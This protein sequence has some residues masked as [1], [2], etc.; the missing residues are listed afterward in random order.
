MSDALRRSIRSFM[1][2]FLGTIISSGVVSAAGTNGVVDWSTLKK[3]VISLV[4]SF[5]TSLLVFGQNYFED[6]GTIP[7]VLKN[8]S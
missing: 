7:A 1:Q 8:P 2:I 5:F 3:I 4:V 6:R